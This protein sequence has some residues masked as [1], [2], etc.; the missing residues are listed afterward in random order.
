MLEFFRRLLNFH[1]HFPFQLLSIILQNNVLS[2]LRIIPKLN[3]AAN[4]CTYKL[5]I[6]RDRISLLIS[7][8]LIQ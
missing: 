6:Q 5:T 2:L 7:V 3:Q 1:I 4:K 8:V